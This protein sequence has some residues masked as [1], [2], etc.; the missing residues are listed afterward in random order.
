MSTTV[1]DARFAKPLDHD[2]IRQL[3]RHH[4]ALITVEQGA[5]GGFG[6]MVLHDLANQGAFDRGL[7]VRTMTLPDRFIDHASPAAMYAE[8]GLTAVDIAA[9]AMEAA[10]VVHKLDKVTR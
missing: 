8:A 7:A 9:T 5:K 6:A 10:G 2:L 1:A 4:K 3:A